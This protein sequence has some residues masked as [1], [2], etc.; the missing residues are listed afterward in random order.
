MVK[1]NEAA[2]KPK[3]KVISIE[4]PDGIF[5]WVSPSDGKLYIGKPEDLET[6]GADPDRLW[7]DK[8][9]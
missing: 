4:L 5:S 6:I 9:L 3:L 1:K 7:F 2:T 8:Y